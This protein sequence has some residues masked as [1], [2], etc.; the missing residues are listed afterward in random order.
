LRY[1]F[2]PRGCP[3]LGSG[4]LGRAWRFSVFGTNIRDAWRQAGIYTGHILKDERPTDLPVRQVTTIDLVINLK[5][6]K[7][8]SLDVPFGL[9]AGVSDVIE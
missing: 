7:A 8:L 1:H 2:G 3:T 9:S 4:L 5:T 6:A